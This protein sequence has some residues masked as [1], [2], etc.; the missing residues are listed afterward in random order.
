VSSVVRVPPELSAFLRLP[1]PQSLMVRGPP[2]SGKTMLS[3]ALMEAFNGRRIFVSLRTTRQNLLDQ[4]PWL[5][6]I[7]PGEF[8]LVDAGAEVDRVELHARAA[9][10]AKDLL[11]DAALSP[12][13][14]DFLLLPGAVQAALGLADHRHP[15]MIVFDSWDAV[16]DQYFERQAPPGDSVPSRTEVERRLLAQMM[17]RQIMLVLVL[18]RDSPSI[19]DYHVDG[20][21][22]TS[23]HAESGRLERWLSMPKLRGV[24]IGTD[25]YPFTLAHGK[26]AAITPTG[27]GERYRFEPPAEDPRPEAEGLWPGST[28]Y[29]T[30]L[31]RLRAGEFTL[32]ELDSTVPREIPRVLI[33]P[34]IVQALRLGGRVLLLPPPSSDPEDAYVSIRE[35]VPV[36]ALRRH[37]RVLSAVQI[38]P[39]SAEL[40]EVYVPTHRIGW[41]KTGLSVP[42]PEDPSFLHEAQG[43]ERFSLVVAYMSGLQ[44]LTESAG[45]TLSPGILAGLAAS[46]FPRG[47]VHGLLVGRSGDPHLDMFGPVMETQL[48]IRCPHGRVFL[49]GHRPYLA[50]LVLSQEAPGEPYRLTP[51]L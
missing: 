31:G 14:Q 13:T 19:L 16:I 44:T 39:G 28:D 11:S 41:T 29:A 38:D 22:E 10:A 42:V 35:H 45:Q 8:E 9:R 32:F 47:K 23:R 15:T 3:L 50:P 51:V 33:G 20:V 36:E 46:V 7:P 4:I 43:S 30:G 27:A 48:R 5:G 34:M 17:H 6:R 24:W 18:E 40:A 12:E 2:G 26:F 25:M 21:V 1:T 49:N 37:L